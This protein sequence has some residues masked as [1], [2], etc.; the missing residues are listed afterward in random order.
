MSVLGFFDMADSC[1]CC[2]MGRSKPNEFGRCVCYCRVHNGF[3]RDCASNECHTKLPDPPDGV[4]YVENSELVRNVSIEMLG[5][6]A[7]TEYMYRGKRMKRA[8][9]REFYLPGYSDRVYKWGQQKVMYPGGSEYTGLEMPEW[10]A[11]IAK[12][13]TESTGEPVNHAIVIAYADGKKNHAPPHHDKLDKGGKYGFFNFSFGSPREFV[14]ADDD[15]NRL[16][17][18]FLKSGSM[19][20][21]SGKANQMWTHA[22][23]V[24]ETHKGMRYSLI[25]RVIV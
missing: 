17:S 6:I 7:M 25:F 5:E 23:P 2:V 4:V 9:K 8:P 18:A 24:D 3:Y 16:W 19:C 13:I 11:D 14:V 22:V 10:M 15:G 20:Y 21:M 12:E 1:D